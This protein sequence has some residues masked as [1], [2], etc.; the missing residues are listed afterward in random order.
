MRNMSKIFTE[1][2]KLTREIKAQYPEV[3]YRAQFGLNLSYLLNKEEAEEVEPTRLIKQL[4]YKDGSIAED[5]KSYKE[6]ALWEKYGHKRMYIN[7]YNKGSYIDLKES[8]V[9]DGRTKEKIGEWIEI[10]PFCGADG[11]AYRWVVA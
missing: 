4:M 11:K 8:M 7:D 1:A 5:W 9:V 2:H 6:L 3:D 10:N